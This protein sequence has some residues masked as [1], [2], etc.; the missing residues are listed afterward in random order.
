[1]PTDE[2]ERGYSAGYRAAHRTDVRDITSDR[3]ESAPS[4]KRKRTRTK[5]K[6]DGK[7]SR[8]L[9]TVNKRAKKKNG[10]FKKG[11]DQ[12]RVMKEAH[13]LARRN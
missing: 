13:K 2:W 7:M 8:A 5:S 11:W 3:G 12:S 6:R 4:P 9:K 10:D 1:M